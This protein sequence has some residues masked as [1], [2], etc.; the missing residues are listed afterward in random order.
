MPVTVR[1]PKC[2]RP[3][4]VPDTFRGQ[5]I[6]CKCGGTFIAAPSNAPREAARTLDAAISAK[7][8]VQHEARLKSPTTAATEDPGS[9][10]RFQIR[11][12]LGA[13]AFGTVYQSY[14]PQLDREVAL[15]VP[16]P[17][18][19]D[20]VQRVER[21]LREAKAAA[22][23]RHP[24]I[25]PV[26][27]AGQHG[28]SHFI[29]SEFIEGQPLAV[30]IDEQSL[31]FRQ[32]AQVVRELAEALDYAHGMGVVHRDVKPANVMLDA[33]GKPHLMDFGLAQRHDST[34]KLT[35]EGALLGTPA[36]MAPEQAR[37][38]SGE[39]LPASDQYSLGATLY[40]L[41]CGQ[42]PFR[43]P[44]EIVIFNVLS[45]EPPSPCKIR[46]D[47]PRDLETICLKTLA[48]RPEDRYPSCQ[49]LSDD[50]RRWQKGEP[51]RAR[52]LHLAERL[53]RWVRKEPKL[54]VALTTV[55]G[56]LLALVAVLVVSERQQRRLTEQARTEAQ[57][58]DDEAR[59]ARDAAGEAQT[60]RDR[61]AKELNRAE[62]LLYANHIYLAQRYWHEV[63]VKAAWEKLQACNRD[64]R[65][66]E[67]DYL[68]TCFTK[69]QRTF[70]GHATRV[71]SV[72]FSPDGG[73][74]VSGGHDGTVKVWDA[75]TGLETL[76]LKGH[77]GAV[78]SVAFSPD[79]KRIVTGGNSNVAI[80]PDGIP[81]VVGTSG[82]PT[83]KVWDAATGREA[84]SLKGGHAWQVTSVAFS[85]DGGRI[86]S[87]GHDGTVKVWD[88]TTGKKTLSIKGYSG[89]VHGVA[90]SPDGGRIVSGGHDGTVKVWDAMTG[91][92]TLSLKGHTGA[93]FSVAFSPDGR[94]IVTGSVGGQTVSP[95]GQRNS[96]T[97][98]T[99]KVWDAATGQET[100]CLKGH[101][102]SVFCVAF[103]LKGHHIVSGSWDQ[104]VK[105]WDATTGQEILAVK[106]QKGAVKCVAFSPD[107]RR[108]VSGGSDSTVKV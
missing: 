90:F 106:A 17:G 85:P 6:R 39:A 95:D 33:K 29:V 89:Y 98:Y 7:A 66:W 46:P 3:G 108:I 1:C 67:H 78:F 87:G 59:K 88:T 42:T 84:L 19:L 37:G 31:N 15:K 50:L 12:R 80:G 13:G 18:T 45:Q 81:R 43:G 56:V 76:P 2:G 74:I 71:S 10:G 68:Y 14:D 93:V 70:R 73:R 52:R 21:F 51:I 35:R 28:T 26:F 107:G 61:K 36:Y 65:G 82:D 48:K 104:T 34:E 92:E 24:Y 27:E 22:Q 102:R 41:L 5:T 57:R 99:V 16:N 62:W 23:L 47:V 30:A 64:F 83:L 58:A 94:R 91:L 100:L 38:Q 103:S 20:N 97:D 8:T 53:V 72:A 86:V 4:N 79:G 105:V 96:S 11:K 101:T 44:P 63:N 54:A 60:E 25:V 49:A 32:T 69:N 9:I 55:A 40:E 75:M 77:T